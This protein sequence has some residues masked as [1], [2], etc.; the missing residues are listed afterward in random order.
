MFVRTLVR[1]VFECIMN[2]ISMNIVI[3]IQ[4]LYRPHT[5]HHLQN[6]LPEFHTSQKSHKSPSLSSSWISTSSSHNHHHQKPLSSSSCSRSHK[7]PC[8]SWVS[9]SS[10]NHRHQKSLSSSSYPRFGPI[11]HHHH[12]HHPLLLS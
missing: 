9:S 4:G 12:H 10:H 5:H 7:S 8:S 11:H 1:I 3:I 6:L 2:K